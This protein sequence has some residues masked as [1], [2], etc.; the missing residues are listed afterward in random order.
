MLVAKENV[1]R[2]PFIAASLLIATAAQAGEP[3]PVKEGQCVMTAIKNIGT[4][5]QGMVGSGDAVTY[6]DGI[7][8]VSYGTITGL[9][10][11]RAGDTVKLCLTGIPDECP[12]GDDRGKTYKATDLRTRKNWEAMNAEHMCGGA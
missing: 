11:A 3:V 10:G 2:L 5:L 8:V 4:R 1:M 7:Y 9:K 6:T 12:P